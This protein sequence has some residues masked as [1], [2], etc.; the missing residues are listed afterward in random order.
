MPTN[1][2]CHLMAQNLLQAWQLWK[3]ETWIELVA[4][5]LVSEEK[6]THTKKCIKIALLCVQE[7]AVDDRPTMSD[8][9]TMLSGKLQ[10]LPEPKQPAFFN[11][12]ATHWELSTSTC[13]SI[14]DLTITI[15]SGR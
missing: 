2:P 7:N 6:M 14:N 3:D 1:S 11:V 10:A 9:V 13:R 4:P 8:V 15:V 5:S 12:R